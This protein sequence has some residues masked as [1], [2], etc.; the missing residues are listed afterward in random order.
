M[1]IKLK[2]I[3]IKNR[4]CFFFDDMINIK[5]LGLNKLKINENSYKNI[6]FIKLDM[7]RSKIL[8]L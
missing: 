3:D 7:L 6:L 4:I 5:N 2:D 1:R 8:N